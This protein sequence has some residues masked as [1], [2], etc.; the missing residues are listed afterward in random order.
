LHFKP[1]HCD[2]GALR[3]TGVCT[4]SSPQRGLGRRVQS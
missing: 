1:A 2:W 4:F 3:H